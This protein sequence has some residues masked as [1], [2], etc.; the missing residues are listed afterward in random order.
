MAKRY[1]K[2]TKLPFRSYSDASSSD[3][4]AF[5]TTRVACNSS[6]ESTWTVVSKCNRVIWPPP[7]R[8]RRPFTEESSQPIA[9]TR[10]IL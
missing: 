5:A 3:I 9:F 6:N 2:R 1:K 4:R 8:N 7:F 10:S